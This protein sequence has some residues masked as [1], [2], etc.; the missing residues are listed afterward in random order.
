M[1]DQI[2]RHAN[3]KISIDVLQA[4]FDDGIHLR[5]GGD[6]GAGVDGERILLGGQH[7]ELWLKKEATGLLDVAPDAAAPGCAMQRTAAFQT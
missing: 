6:A 3:F 4:P 1:P 7:A 2:P 5:A